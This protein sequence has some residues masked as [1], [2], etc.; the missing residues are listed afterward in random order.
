M[1]ISSTGRKNYM[2]T[3]QC[4][5]AGLPMFIVVMQ[6]TTPHLSGHSLLVLDRSFLSNIGSLSQPN[7]QGW[8]ICWPGVDGNQGREGI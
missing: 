5:V 7:S 3:T 8:G 4:V 1:H 2:T 6:T